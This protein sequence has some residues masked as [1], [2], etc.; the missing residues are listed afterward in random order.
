MRFTAALLLLC[1]TFLPLPAHAD[2][3]SGLLAAERGDYATAQRELLPLQAD[4]RAAFVLGL[5]ADHGLGTRMDPVAAA[6]F[7][8]QAARGGHPSAMVNLG[9]L[10]DLGRGV[11]RDGYVAQQLYA[12]AARANNT[13]GKNNLA[14]LWGRQNGLLEEALCLSAQTIQDQPHNPYFLDTYGF[15]LLRLD[16]LDDAKR[17]FDAALREGANYAVALEHL[18]DIA[19]MRGDDAAARSLWQRALEAAQRLPDSQRLQRKLAGQPDDL[20]MH[21]PF[22]LDRNGFGRDCAMPSV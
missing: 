16:R 3:D 20:D 7:Y 10:Y 8:A 18:G 4:P 14:Y 5:M 13:M 17:F 9:Q 11:P 19:R 12:A 22:K 2:L 1:L 21:A 15:I 6:R